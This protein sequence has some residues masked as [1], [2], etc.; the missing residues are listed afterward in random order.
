MSTD[1]NSPTAA[2]MVKN[3]RD[4]LLA[5]CDDAAGLAKVLDMTDAQVLTEVR[6]LVIEHLAQGP[7]PH[8]AGYLLYL[9]QAIEN[10]EATK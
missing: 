4:L 5:D 10:L 3:A 7:N 6:V 9:D 1:K 2:E 8:I